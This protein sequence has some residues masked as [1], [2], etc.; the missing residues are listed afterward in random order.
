MLREVLRGVPGLTREM[1]ARTAQLVFRV[2]RWW[3]WLEE[4]SDWRERMEAADALAERFAREPARFSEGAL[5]KAVPDWIHEHM[6]VTPA[7][8][9]LLQEEPVL[10]LRGR[11]G[12]GPIVAL[13]LGEASCPCPLVPEA[14]RYDGGQDLFR[15]AMFQGGRIEVQDVASQWVTLL[16]GPKA[17][18]SWWDA[19][20]GEGGKAL[21]MADLMDNRGVVWATDRAE[22]R[23][24]RLRMR[25]GR[26]GLFNVRWAVWE[27]GAKRPMTPRMDGVLV[28]AP[29][30][31]VGTWRRNP[32]A[33]WTTTPRDVA[34]LAGR[35]LALLQGASRGVKPG[36][37][38]V[39]SVCTLTRAETTGVARAFE[40]G[41]AAF[42]PLEWPVA[43]GAE[44]GPGRPNEAWFPSERW[45]GNGMYVAGWR[46]K[47]DA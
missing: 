34:E 24:K 3:G 35:Q 11:P 23:L 22:W 44:P 42:E 14:V 27:G 18:E 25:V 45:G 32:Q 6:E 7:W 29:C 47:E 12:Q 10:W 26:A 8:L 21:H 19:C 46:R 15:S 37:R 30:S 33:R 41:N 20:A 13:E 5:R 4:R 2:Y 9:R 17:G 1:A 40:A 38:L 28:D 31:G 36:G 16:A 43:A 39:Y